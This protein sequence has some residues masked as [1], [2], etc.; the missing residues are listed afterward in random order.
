M[1][2]LY[3]VKVTIVFKGVKLEGKVSRLGVNKREGGRMCHFGS[4]YWT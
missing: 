2:S 4:G 1:Q 3:M